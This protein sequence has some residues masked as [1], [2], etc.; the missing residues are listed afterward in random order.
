MTTQSQKWSARDEAQLQELVAR[1]EK[2]MAENR[3]PVK[4]LV[5]QAMSSYNGIQEEDLVN[6]LIA[7]ADAFLDALRPF[8]SG[9]R[10]G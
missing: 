9:I 1:R 7:N 10:K 6:E 4:N 5:S 2:V 8:D 3:A